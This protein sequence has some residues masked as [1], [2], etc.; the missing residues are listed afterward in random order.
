MLSFKQYSGLL[1]EGGA[2]GHMSHPFDLPNVKTG[3][4]LIELFNNTVKYLKA[5]PAILKIDGINLSIRLITAGNKFEF[6]IDRG[7]N[8]PLDLAG[9]T[10][11][12]LPERFLRKDPTT[13]VI[14][15]NID[16][17]AKCKKTL[18]IFNNAI[19][20]I[21]PLLKQLEM[22]GTERYINL[23]YVE[24]QGNV[25]TYDTE[26]L[27][28]HN[29]KE[30]TYGVT[31]KTKKRTRIKVDPEYNEKAL[32]ELSQALKPF[33]AEYDFNVYNKIAA[34]LMSSPDFDKVLAAPFTIKTTNDLIETKPLGQWLKDLNNPV[35]TQV[36][37]LDG[38]TRK[39]ISK[40]AI[41][42]PITKGV[43]LVDFI[44]SKSFNDA[45]AGAIFYQATRMLGN[46]LLLNVETPFGSA[47]KQEG[48]VINNA[49]VAPEVFKITGEFII[50]G[51]QSRFHTSKLKNSGKTAVFTFGRFNPPTLAHEKIMG[52]IRKTGT[53][54][55]ADLVAVF[56]TYTQNKKTDP[57]N[58]NEKAAYLR[59]F[60]LP[61]VEILPQGKTL[62]AV[63]KYLSDNGYTK[64]IQVAGSDRIPEYEK[65]INMYNNKPS[66]TQHEILFNIPDYTFKS[67][68][69]RDPDAEGFK[70]MSATAARE[71]IKRN[72]RAGFLKIVAPGGTNTEAEADNKDRLFRRL[73]EI[74]T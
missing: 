45:K 62:F 42:I 26:F 73:R 43:P 49:K 20:T 11:D 16:L 10:I 66:K 58:F 3:D 36:A 32:F 53:E 69:Q 46:E 27:V 23:E 65:L 14:A 22:I 28:L 60:A 24:K 51:L 7:T 48:I 12:K 2:G 30:F 52:L 59:S 57:L 17:I 68:G 55:K 29:I 63:L 41:Y 19:P 50:G 18:T 74:L 54:V 8:M 25:I 35:E 5:A 40:E 31:E 70:G 13:D 6:A 61:G 67:A 39:A 38:A 4:D 37:F 44:K 71:C 33:A 1:E 21:M 64:V 9:V 72:D 56:P 47:S 15:P 34:T